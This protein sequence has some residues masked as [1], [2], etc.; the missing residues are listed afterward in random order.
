MQ[1]KSSFKSPQFSIILLLG[2]LLHSGLYA[3][4]T[5]RFEKAPTYEI[6]ALADTLNS[7]SDS[8]NQFPDFSLTKLNPIS[9]S[10]PTLNNFP[11][12]PSNLN[13]S[14]HT[15]TGVNEIYSVQKIQKLNNSDLGINA[16]K[17]EIPAVSVPAL[18]EMP[19]LKTK[20]EEEAG[21]AI[22]SR[23]KKNKLNTPQLEEAKQIKQELDSGNWE[24]LERKAEGALANQFEDLGELQGLEGTSS[25][26]E[27]T[28]IQ[29][30]NWDESKVAASQQVAQKLGEHSDKIQTA[31]KE[32]EGLKKKYSKVNLMNP[33]GPV[34]QQM[35]KTPVDRWSF[36]LGLEAKWLNGL[37]LKTAPLV[38]FKLYNKW[39]IG[40][41]GSADMLIYHKDNLTAKFQQQVSYRVFSQY[42]F[43]RNIFAHA[44]FE[45]P[46][47]PKSPEIR[48]NWYDLKR[49]KQKG[50]LGLGVEYKIYRKLKGQTQ[51]LYNFLEDFENSKIAIR[52]NIII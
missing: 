47:T 27:L 39:S 29:E 44:E 34:L 16:G 52:V 28:S 42:K 10:L 35:D 32:M 50:W 26:E 49:N 18:P 41:S 31:L 9:D 11:E 33:N 48:E 20:A 17:R 22:N 15:M 7:F 43:Y 36:G 38:A 3:Q 23:L 4:D 6:S 12:F 8:V 37:M 25:L 13:D 1:V 2:F 40:L 5:I 46:Y 51:I 24:K 19:Q 14:L 45:Q 30:I 21:K